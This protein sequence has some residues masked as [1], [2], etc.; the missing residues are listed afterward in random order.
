M[1]LKTVAVVIVACWLCAGCVGDTDNA[2]DPDETQPEVCRGRIV[3]PIVA[4]LHFESGAQSGVTD[5]DGYFNYEV[6]KPIRLSAAGVI[7]AT[8]LIRPNNAT[9]D[10]ARVI[11]DSATVE[12]SSLSRVELEEAPM[13]MTPVHL[14]FN[15]TVVTNVV[16]LLMMLD[17]DGNPDNGVQ[18]SDALQAAP[19]A[20]IDLSTTDLESVAAHIQTAAIAADGASHLWSPGAAA[21]SYL[22]ARQTCAFTGLYTGWITSASVHGSLT[23]IVFPPFGD[24]VGFASTW[25]SGPYASGLFHFSIHMGQQSVGNKTGAEID[26]VLHEQGHEWPT[27]VAVPSAPPLNLVFDWI[28]TRL[29][30]AWRLETNDGTFNA[31]QVIKQPSDA[32]FSAVHRF[33]QFPTRWTHAQGHSM[34]DVLVVEIDRAGAV[35]VRLLDP[36]PSSFGYA[37]VSMQGPVSSNSE[38]TATKDGW[39][40]N[41]LFD[42]DAMILRNARLYQPGASGMALADDFNDDPI[43]GCSL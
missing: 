20:T 6:G 43:V 25:P 29:Q 38:V 28:G 24:L 36:K 4:G 9:S 7:L 15:P 26:A 32:E 30:G 39:K 12:L 40:F 41:A 11:G 33:V 2:L 31:Q 35:S 19:A 27:A 14:S 21:T 23:A 8:I 5:A 1:S 17:V 18:I 42:R 37:F 22:L 13:M 10:T 3:A 16:R 34:Y